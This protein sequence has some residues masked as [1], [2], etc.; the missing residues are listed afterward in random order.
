MRAAL[1]ALLLAGCATFGVEP[2]RGTRTTP[3]A[4]EYYL[5]TAVGLPRQLGRVDKR[6][7]MHNPTAVPIKVHVACKSIRQ[8]DIDIVMAPRTTRWALVEAL[9]WDAGVS[10]CT[11]GW[12]P[13]L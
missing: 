7:D 4:E 11:F 9:W 3:Y 13:A 8:P 6:L 5:G 10:T 2:Y 1:V 12:E